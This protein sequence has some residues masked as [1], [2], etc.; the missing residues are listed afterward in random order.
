MNLNSTITIKEKKYQFKKIILCVGKNLN[1]NTN[2]DDIKNQQ[3]SYVGFF[4]H[5]KNHKNIA[6]EIFTKHGP[7]AVLPSPDKNNLMSTFI[8]SS[9]KDIKKHEIIGLIRKNFNLSHGNINI[10]TVSYTHL[11]LPTKQPV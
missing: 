8:Y 4:Y 9:K 7:L 11:T 10:T 2:I 3:F 6:Y 1:F 5:S